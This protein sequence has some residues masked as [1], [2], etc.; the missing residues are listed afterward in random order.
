MYCMIQTKGTAK[1]TRQ[2][3]QN[4][5]KKYMTFLT[6]NQLHVQCFGIIGAG[7]AS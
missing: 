7:V 1:N 6:R 2:L 4:K 5:P 3:S